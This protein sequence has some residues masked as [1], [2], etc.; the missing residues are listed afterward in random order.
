MY[1][2][3]CRNLLWIDPHLASF[4]PDKSLERMVLCLA[5]Q[6]IL[7]RTHRGIGPFGLLQNHIT[8]RQQGTV[9]LPKDKQ[10]CATLSLLVEPTWIQDVRNELDSQSRILEYMEILESTT[11]DKL[12]CQARTLLWCFSVSSSSGQ[13]LRLVMLRLVRNKVRS[14]DSTSSILPKP[15]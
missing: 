6:W 12:S 5:Y 13:K 8:A 7:W 1:C 9:F 15:W 10:T 3:G 2:I 14:L 4:R 11:Q